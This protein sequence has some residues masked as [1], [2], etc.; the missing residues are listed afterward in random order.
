MQLQAYL[1]KNK[2]SYSDFA[3]Q[4]GSEGTSGYL[5]IWRYATKKRTPRLKTAYKIQ[6]ITKGKVAIKDFYGEVNA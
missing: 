3:K 6:E 5:R 2:I 4:L 1:D